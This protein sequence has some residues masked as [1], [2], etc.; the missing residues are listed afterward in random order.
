V[1]TISRDGNNITLSWTPD[2]TVVGYRIA[3]SKRPY[4]QPDEYQVSYAGVGPTGAWTH[5]GAASSLDNWCYLVQ[6]V[7]I[8]NNNP[9][10]STPSNRKCEFTFSLVN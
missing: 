10:F 2:P 7:K 9:Q 4:F 6:A 1:I 8:V 5:T 3:Y